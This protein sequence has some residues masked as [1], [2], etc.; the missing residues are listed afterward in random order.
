MRND[1]ALNGRKYPITEF[2]TYKGRQIPV[3][4]L[5]QMPDTLW[6]EIARKQKEKKSL[7]RVN[8]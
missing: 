4:E 1:F 3:I 7:E 2:N 6:N 8:G 5:N